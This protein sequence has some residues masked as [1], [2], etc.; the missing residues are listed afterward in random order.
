MSRRRRSGQAGQEPARENLREEEDEDEGEEKEEKEEVV[1]L[2]SSFGVFGWEMCS[3]QIPLHILKI[4]SLF[5]PPALPLITFFPF[6][7]E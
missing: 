7:T 5:S 4:L 2:W 3:S 1:E 6:S